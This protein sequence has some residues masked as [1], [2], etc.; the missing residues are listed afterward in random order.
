MP[1]NQHRVRIGDRRLTD[2]RDGRSFAELVSDQ[3][4]ADQ[5]LIKEAE[6]AIAGD[7]DAQVGDIDEPVV[8][9]DD[10]RGHE[11]ELSTPLALEISP[12]SFDDADWQDFRQN[13]RST[14]MCSSN[15]E[16]EPPPSDE[17]LSRPSCP[18]WRGTAGI[19]PRAK[20][21]PEATSPAGFGEPGPGRPP[22]P[23]PPPPLPDLPTDT[24]RRADLF[25]PSN[26]LQRRFPP[27]ARTAGLRIGPGSRQRSCRPVLTN[28][29]T[30]SIRAR[31]VD[32]T[33]VDSTA[34]PLTW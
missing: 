11:S 22:P 20:P 25:A 2:D 29:S 6:S 27:S 19:R 33:D 21:P 4:A 12:V 9:V 13:P 26:R 24:L 16:V 15:D 28:W 23:P 5:S 7:L 32:V 30:G 31:D 18:C 8:V 34:S 17:S 14:T 3:F 1:L 10:E